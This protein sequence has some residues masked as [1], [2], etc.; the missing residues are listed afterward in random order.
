MALLVVLLLVAPKRP[1]FSGKTA[2]QWLMMLDAHV[3]KRT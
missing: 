1:Q 3:D 2:T